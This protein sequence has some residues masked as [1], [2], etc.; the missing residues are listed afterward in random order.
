M[1]ENARKYAIQNVLPSY[2]D[3]FEHFQSNTWGRN[4]LLRKGINAAIALYHLREH[5]PENIRPKQDDLEKY[6]DDYGLLGNIAN[7]SKHRKITRNKPRISDATQIFECMTGMYCSDEQGFYIAPQLEVFLK[8]DDGTERR[9]T[10]VLYNVLCMWRDLLEQLGVV[11]LKHPE[12]LRITDHVS[13]ESATKRRS[14]L[15]LTPGE[16]HRFQFRILGIQEP[17]DI[18]KWSAQFTVSTLPE[19]VPIRITL[20]KD[21]REFGFDFDVPLTEEQ[22]VQYIYQTTN[23][24]KVTFAQG[25]IDSSPQIQEE[26][27]RA[28]ESALRSE[29]D[30][31]AS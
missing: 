10:E 5:L 20:S 3:Y 7:V 13:R 21:D 28:I 11:N 4:Q 12:P 18:T 22:A 19:Y 26:L 6:C 27:A 8:L 2:Y 16:D 17:I 1:F 23:E 24:E 9:L 29:E 15:Q 25:I 14:D 31:G 30:K